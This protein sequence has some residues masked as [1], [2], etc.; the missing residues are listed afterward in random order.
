MLLSLNLYKQDGVFSTHQKLKE[1]IAK[2]SESGLIE[3]QTEGSSYRI[4]EEAYKTIL[5]NCLLTFKGRKKDLIEKVILQRFKANPLVSV[6]VL[7]F[8]PDSEE[9]LI[10]HLAEVKDLTLTENVEPLTPPSD[11]LDL[12]EPAETEE[13]EKTQDKKEINLTDEVK[14]EKLNGKSRPNFLTIEKPSKFNLENY[15][16]KFVGKLINLVSWFN[17]FIKTKEA[18]TIVLMSS[19][20]IQCKH[21]RHLYANASGENPDEN[22]IS[23]Y[24]FAGAVVLTAMV[25]TTNRDMNVVE[26]EKVVGWFAFWDFFVNVLYFRVWECELKETKTKTTNGYTSE[27]WDWHFNDLDDL[28]IKLTLSAIFAFVILTYGKIWVKK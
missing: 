13:K 1:K 16:V 24:I 11:N 23:S 25:I 19:L 12:T 27:Y 22:S 5:E 7:D 18:A 17:H 3:Y 28:I 26:K 14:P 20:A 21:I 15:L 10:E 6:K 8:V 2:L 9:E 4:T